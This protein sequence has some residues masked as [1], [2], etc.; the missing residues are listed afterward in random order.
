MPDALR[1]IVG[2]H[3]IWRTLGS[4]TYRQAAELVRLERVRIDAL[5][6]DARQSAGLLTPLVKPGRDVILAAVWSFFHQLEADNRVDPTLDR[7][8][9]E[10]C[11]D[12][13][14]QDAGIVSAD[15]VDLQPVAKSVA[16]TEAFPSQQAHRLSHS[17]PR[18]CR[19]PW[20][21]M[22]GDRL[23][24]WRAFVSS[25]AILRSLASVQRT[26]LRRGG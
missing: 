20:L 6:A 15:P 22:P 14:I 19:P 16:W 11:L 23:S 18:L 24:D 9:R 13:A 1:P 21:S 7:R 2:K 4:V 3:E 12:R 10:E 25:S 26:H 5:F 8:E 17:L